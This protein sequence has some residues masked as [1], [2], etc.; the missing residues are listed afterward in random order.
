MHLQIFKRLEDELVYLFENFLCF[1]LHGLTFRQ[2]VHQGEVE[3][4]GRFLLNPNLITFNSMGNTCAQKVDIIEQTISSKTRQAVG[5]KAQVDFPLTDIEVDLLIQ[6]WSTA[7][8]EWVEI[9]QT[10]FKRC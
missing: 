7:E 10:A 6:S 5:R 8:E 9:Y 2:T 1:F 3:N 4:V